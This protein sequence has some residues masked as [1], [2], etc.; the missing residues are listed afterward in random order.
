MPTKGSKGQDWWK[1]Q[2]QLAFVSERALRPLQELKANTR[3][4]DIV[5]VLRQLDVAVLDQHSR[6]VTG[7]VEV[8]KRLTKVGMHDYGGFIHK[9]NTLGA[10]TVVIL[11]EAGFTSPVLKHVRGLEGQTVRLARMHEVD[12]G[13]ISS[14]T[15]LTGLTEFANH[16]WVLGMFYQCVDNE[17]G[18]LKVDVNDP[19][20]MNDAGPR[21]SVMDVLAVWERANPGSAAVPGLH[22]ICLDFGEAG[23]L[24]WN[25]KWL[26][27]LMVCFELRRKVV[28]RD[29]RFF[30]Y[31]EVFPSAGRQGLIM[32]S[33]IHVEGSGVGTLDMV[34][35][36]M[37]TQDVR[38]YGQ[39][40]FD[41]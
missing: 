14:A 24:R 40:A 4:R 8:Q 23:P 22:N 17:A 28:E 9:R 19:V 16:R 27:R 15:T 38:V 37:G 7:L 11:S 34:M 30:A 29:V 26:R 1:E 13:K 12:A 36:P 35:M 5:N 33:L 18:F 3:V 31:D 20:F 21:A 25:G 32:R 2:E 6:Q 39:L 10:K 41:N